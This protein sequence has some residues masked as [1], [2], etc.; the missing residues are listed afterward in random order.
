MRTLFIDRDGIVNKKAP[1]HEYITSWNEFSFIPE[2]FDILRYYKD[3]GFEFI[4]VTN[5]QCIGKGILSRNGLE[6]IHKLM[7]EEFKS[8]KIHIKNIYYC[9]HLASDNCNCRKPKTGMLENAV[10]DFPGINI[11]NSYIIGD[12]ESDIIA[13]QDFG[14]KTIY[15]GNENVKANYNYSNLK[16]MLFDLV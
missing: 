6:K 1:P 14:L 15:I 2:I 12:S 13:G 16:E 11:D 5:Q 3:S 9:P 8:H 10:E 7:L 4:I